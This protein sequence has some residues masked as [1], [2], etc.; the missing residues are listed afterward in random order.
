MYTNLGR[1]VEK[2]TGIV[3]RT[4][5]RE[6]GRK[7]GRKESHVPPIPIPSLPEL[8]MIMSGKDL[9]TIK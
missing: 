2:F 8:K 9:G 3:G 7:K 5:G 4:E 6:E 1:N